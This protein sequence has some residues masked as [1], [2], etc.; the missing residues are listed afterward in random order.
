MIGA[1]VN[2]AGS[3]IVA[4]ADATVDTIANVPDP[5]A[6]LYGSAAFIAVV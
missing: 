5:A 1:N 2:P 4:V 3:V 6:N